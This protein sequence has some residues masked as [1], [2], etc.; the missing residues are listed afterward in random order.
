MIS[1]MCNKVLLGGQMFSKAVQDFG[2]VSERILSPALSEQR[3]T[4]E[5]AAFIE[6]YCLQL[7]AMIASSKDEEPPQ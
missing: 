4:L 6:Y 7:L 1:Q 2:L 3:L 5:E